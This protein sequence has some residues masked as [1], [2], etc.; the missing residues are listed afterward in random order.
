V[1]ATEDRQAIE[2]VIREFL[3]SA[4]RAKFP[5]G[6]WAEPL[7]DAF[8]VGTAIGRSTPAKLPVLSGSAHVRKLEIRSIEGDSANVELNAECV[9]KVDHPIGGHRHIRR[10]YSGGVL[11]RR[12]GEQWRIITLKQDG[13]DFA[14]ATFQ[15]VVARAE[16]DGVDLSLTTRY[17]KADWFMG[18]LFENHSSESAILDRVRSTQKVWWLFED[19]V[20]V[21]H[22]PL[23]LRNG[24]SWG[25]VQ[26]LK[27]RMLLRPISVTARV[28]GRDIG[29]EVSPPRIP[30]LR[31]IRQSVHPNTMLH[32]FVLTALL[33][34]PIASRA[35]GALGLA[36]VSAGVF[37]IA[38]EVLAALRASRFSAQLL[39][40]IVGVIE[41]GV[42]AFLV[43]H[44][45]VSTITVVGL[46]LVVAY[47]LWLQ[48]RNLELWRKAQAETV[49]D[50]AT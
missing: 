2:A 18:L 17:G 34:L 16:I 37:N 49:R 41:L 23:V 13:V 50:A 9:T 10:V 33:L 32:A 8:A 36:L 30:L 31:R 25:L 27:G 22:T 40:G 5:P 3:D 39:Y 21:R 38:S 28:N 15:P 26:G 48:F 7:S 4:A 47:W 6:F 35:P 19:G 12:E 1:G 11:L 44:E 45:R 46:L 43:W 14:A 20:V 29:L 24:G 42:G